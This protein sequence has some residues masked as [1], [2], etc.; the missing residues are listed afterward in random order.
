MLRTGRSY[1][2]PAFHG[3]IFSDDLSGMAAI[4]EVPD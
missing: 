4:T 3:V 1:N 2:G